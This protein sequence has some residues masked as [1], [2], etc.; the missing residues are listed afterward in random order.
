VGRVELTEGDKIQRI[1]ILKIDTEGQDAKV[2]A[3]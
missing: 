1:T 3:D 2:G